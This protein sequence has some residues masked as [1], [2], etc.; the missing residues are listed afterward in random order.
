MYLCCCPDLHIM[1]KMNDMTWKAE[2]NLQVGKMYIII[3]LDAE[4]STFMTRLK[5]PFCQKNFSLA[6][7]PIA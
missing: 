3:I 7:F 1:N 4:L 2:N 6:G 5:K